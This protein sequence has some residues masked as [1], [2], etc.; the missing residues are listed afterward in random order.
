VR[1]PDSIIET[2]KFTVLRW[3]SKGPIRV[4][5]TVTDN[6]QIIDLW[7]C[8]HCGV[9]FDGNVPV[10][11]RNVIQNQPFTGH[12]PDCAG[13]WFYL[14]KEQYEYYFSIYTAGSIQS[15]EEA[16]KQA[17]QKLQ[18]IAQTFLDESAG[19]FDGLEVSE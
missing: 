14:I 13:S 11:V 9:T 19:A 8:I 15:L 16:K 4:E 5:L 2:P 18:S 1:H 10:E 7:D 17:S 6:P 3:Y 12:N